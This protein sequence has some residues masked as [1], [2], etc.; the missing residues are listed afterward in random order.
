MDQELK[1]D[2]DQNNMD[3]SHNHLIETSTAPA[4][5]AKNSLDG[6]GPGLIDTPA[7]HPI[8]PVDQPEQPSHFSDDSSDEAEEKN[9][10]SDATVSDVD[11]LADTQPPAIP[12]RAEARGI[13]D[14]TTE[15]HAAIARILHEEKYFNSSPQYYAHLILGLNPE[16]TPVTRRHLKEAFDHSRALTRPSDGRD[17]HG[18]MAFRAVHLAFDELRRVARPCPHDADSH[19]EGEDSDPSSDSI[20]V[21]AEVSDIIAR[22]RYRHSPR[23]FAVDHDEDIFIP[24]RSQRLFK[25]DDQGR[26]LQGRDQSG[27]R[28]KI[29]VFSGVVEGSKEEKDLARESRLAKREE[30]FSRGRSNSRLEGSPSSLRSVRSADDL[31]RNTTA[32]GLARRSSIGAQQRSSVDAVIAG[33][34]FL[35]EQANEGFE[36]AAASGDEVDTEEGEENVSAPDGKV[37]GEGEAGAS[38][39]GDDGSDNNS[40]DTDSHQIDELDDAFVSQEALT[41]TRAQSAPAA[42]GRT[43]GREDH[44]AKR[45][46]S[47][48]FAPTGS[49]WADDDDDNQGWASIPIHWDGVGSSVSPSGSAP[50]TPL[51]S[52]N[53]NDDDACD[54]LSAVRSDSPATRKTMP[55]GSAALTDRPQSGDGTRHGDASL[56]LDIDD[57]AGAKPSPATPGTLVGKDESPASPTPTSASSVDSTTGMSQSQGMAF[58][59]EFDEAAKYSL[60][61]KRSQLIDDVEESGRDMSQNAPHLLSRENPQDKIELLQAKIHKLKAQ[62]RTMD[63]DVLQCELN[64]LR[65][66]YADASDELTRLRYVEDGYR[67]LKARYDN[68]VES[69]RREFAAFQRSL[70]DQK[71][72]NQKLLDARNNAAADYNDLLDEYDELQNQVLA[73]GRGVDAETQTAESSMQQLR[74]RDQG[75]DAPSSTDNT[76][77]NSAISM[78]MSGVDHRLARPW[79]VA[80]HDV[81]STHIAEWINAAH[82]HEGGRDIDPLTP[83]QVQDILKRDATFQHTLGTLMDLGFLFR[84]DRFAQSLVP[85]LR[86]SGARDLGAMA[87]E[88]GIRLETRTVLDLLQ[89]IDELISEGEYRSRMQRERDEA[90]E[91]N[92]AQVIVQRE[93]QGRLQIELWS[94]EEVIRLLIANQ[95]DGSSLKTVAREAEALKEKLELCRERGKQLAS[96]KEQL[97]EEQAAL[98]KQL[99]ACHEHGQQLEATNEKLEQAKSDLEKARTDLT[100][101]LTTERDNGAASEGNYKK[102]LGELDEANK[103]I[104]SLEAEVARFKRASSRDTEEERDEDLAD[105]HA[106][107]KE[108]IEE[109]EQE[110]A[111]AQSTHYNVMMAAR[112]HIE[113]LKAQIVTPAALSATSP[114]A[115][116]STSGQGAPQAGPGQSGDQAWGAEP[117]PTAPRPSNSYRDDLTR[118]VRRTPEYKD[119]RERF[120]KLR[121]EQEKEEAE[122][123]EYQERAAYNLCGWRKNAMPVSTADRLA[124]WKRLAALTE[125]K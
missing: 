16:Q 103:T 1:N 60:S 20:E 55:E 5:E 33:L 87:A 6:N 42:L 105:E 35:G 77:D 47:A 85:V 14:T 114:A 10:N 26:V 124:S 81:A 125:P 100:E 98:K 92:D 66:S 61:K 13:L 41:R 27:H 15:R 117:K 83:A 17:W 49:N 65:H 91:M 3:T 111:N 52:P 121:K 75:T 102:L 107:L 50:S 29:E 110:L 37:V 54:S 25:L 72:A 40:S 34:A 9:E 74:A 22:A 97:E 94:R 119:E 48:I 58:S 88:R 109:L 45:P 24:N 112:N 89:E 90:R 84:P 12:A 80:V 28:G 46:F 21:T 79:P 95:I 59:R 8:T 56:T 38:S 67:D 70:D 116:K 69:A 4:E 62:Y 104:V 39:D 82:A 63:V 64:R 43:F 123:Q 113:R 78:P 73:K 51:L 115:L 96:V 7:Q 53:E 36:E 68:Y 19:D 76:S 122:V 31:S 120:R 23:L 44:M 99:Q 86:G 93:E 11:T 118:Q 106:D 30:W 2:V 108:R 57:T 101:L 71:E 32:P 18:E